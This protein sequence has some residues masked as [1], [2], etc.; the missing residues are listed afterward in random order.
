MI[1]LENSLAVAYK[2]EQFNS[3]LKVYAIETKATVHKKTYTRIFTVA[4]L[5]IVPNWKE[6]TSIDRRTD[7]QVGYF[8]YSRTLHNKKK[9][10]TTYTQ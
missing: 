5:I 3:F 6:Q 2:V 8:S 4:L 7:N 10:G 1:T 9:E